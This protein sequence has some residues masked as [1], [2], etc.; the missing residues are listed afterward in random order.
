M[1]S[2]DDIINLPRPQSARHPMPVS[3]R[4][5][6]FQPFAALKGHDEVIQERQKL[7]VERVELAEERKEE[8]DGS[9]A[10]LV[11]CLTCGEKPM[12]TI[13]HFVVDEKVSA[14]EG[15]ELGKY[16]ETTGIVS[17]IDNIKGVLK[18]G[19]QGISMEDIVDIKGNDLFTK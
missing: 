15:R 18:I 1:G 6:I 4:A 11:H 5:K 7:T 14:E 8:L 9:V 19:E 10:K 17:K 13:V 16:V 3:D 12:I 2:Y